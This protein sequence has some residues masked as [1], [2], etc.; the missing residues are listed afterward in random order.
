MTVMSPAAARWTPPVTGASSMRMPFA[1]ESAAS[2]SISFWSSVLISIQVPPAFKPDRMPS[3]PVSTACEIAGEGRQVDN[4]IDAGCQRLR[5]VGP[6][7]AAFQQWFRT[8][9]VP[10][11]NGER[12]T[13]AHETA[14]QV[15]AQ[16]PKSDKAVAHIRPPFQVAPG[17][18]KW[19][20]PPPAMVVIVSSRIL[21]DHGCALFRPPSSSVH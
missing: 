9:A 17:V 4:G 18:M 20:H 2:L 1:A 10:V 13:L 14:R 21:K 19:L 6:Q 7:R 3:G 5:T 15:L 16:M 11:V 12:K 8:A